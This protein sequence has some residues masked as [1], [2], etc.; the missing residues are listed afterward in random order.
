M[1]RK[2][3]WYEE[4]EDWKRVERGTTTEDNE[5]QIMKINGEIKEEM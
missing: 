5:L 3:T 2:R 4:K 1:C